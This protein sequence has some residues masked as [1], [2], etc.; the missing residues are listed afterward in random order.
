MKRRN[1]AMSYETFI[2]LEKAHQSRDEEESLLAKDSMILFRYGSYLEHLEQDP[3]LIEKYYQ[4]SLAVDPFNSLVLSHYG[5]FLYLNRKRYKKGQHYLKKAIQVFENS[6]IPIN[7][8]NF[9]T[10]KMAIYDYEDYAK[11]LFLNPATS[12]KA[13]KYQQLAQCLKIKLLD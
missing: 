5:K 7:D 10:I 4:L 11:M 1:F 2:S 6:T 8:E 3:L 9:L 12:K 13:I